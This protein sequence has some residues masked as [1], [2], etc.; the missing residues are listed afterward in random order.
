Y[1]GMF[2]AVACTEDAPLI[3][4]VEAARRSEQSVFDDRTVVFS[5]VCSE[6]EQGSVS[7]EFREP[8][9]S[10]VPVLILSGEAD[11]IT[12]PRHAERVAESLTNELHLVFSG[13]G[14]GN[15]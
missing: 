10:D 14:H 5:A 7:T 4:A 12:P 13:M 15:L 8:I 3:S 11:P 1:D 9:I 2:Y 6:W